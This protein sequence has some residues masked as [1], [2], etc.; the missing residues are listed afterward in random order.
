MRSIPRFFECLRAA[1]RSLGSNRGPGART[2]A[3]DE[4]LANNALLNQQEAAF[5]VRLAIEVRR[6]QRKRKMVGREAKPDAV[7]EAARA[8]LDGRR[9]KDR[10]EVMARVRRAVVAA[11]LAQ[12]KERRITA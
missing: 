1:L 8:R 6:V 5:V 4:L 12:A 3:T 9:R 10:L 7:L 11:E 2:T